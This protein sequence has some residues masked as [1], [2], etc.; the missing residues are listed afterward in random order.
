[1]SGISKID[2]SLHCLTLSLLKKMVYGNSCSK[3]SLPRRE[4]VTKGTSS[5][6]L[7]KR[8]TDD[9]KR[10]LSTMKEDKLEV[11]NMF[12]WKHW[13]T[14][15]QAELYGQPHYL[16]PPENGVRRFLI[17]FRNGERVTVKFLLAALQERRD[18][19]NY[20]FV[21]KRTIRGDDDDR[22]DRTALVMFTTDAHKLNHSFFRQITWELL[23]R[24]TTDCGMC[25]VNQTSDLPRETETDVD[26]I[27]RMAEL[28]PVTQETHDDIQRIFEG[29]RKSLY[30]AATEAIGIQIKQNVP[31][32]EFAAV[33]AV[34]GVVSGYC[35]NVRLEEDLSTEVCSWVNAKLNKGL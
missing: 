22:S 3:C 20:F 24:C 35:A 31:H 1:M 12:G 17:Y 32:N 11:L 7:L 15:A 28:T 25:L 18:N 8:K 6:K 9:L 23:I 16:A 27:R 10:A 21:R 4:R 19:P 30:K 33:G 5:K 13:F 34:S 29:E 14:D 26:L 2:I